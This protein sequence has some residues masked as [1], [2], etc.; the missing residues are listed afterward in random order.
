MAR[1]ALL[2]LFIFNFKDMVKR[3]KTGLV[4]LALFMILFVY[5]N[6]VFAS[7]HRYVNTIEDFNELSEKTNIDVIFYGSSHAYTA[8]NPLIINSECKT[9]SYNLGSD[10][11]KISMTD[12]VLE[13][14]IKRTR[15]KLII[16]EVYRGIL[17]VSEY[18][19]TSKGLQLRALDLVSNISLKKLSEMR[20][21]YNKDE[22]LGAM[23]PLIRNHSEWRDKSFTELSKRVGFEDEDFYSSGYVGYGRIIDMRHKRANFLDFRN[24][25]RKINSKEH[26]LNEEVK[27]SIN[28]FIEIAKEHSIPVL[29]VTSPDLREPYMNNFLFIEFD[30]FFSNINVP[31]LNLNDFYDEMDLTINDFRDPGHLNVSGGVKVTRFLSNYI[32]KNYFLENRSSERVWRNL[33]SVYK[34]SKDLLKSRINYKY[35]NSEEFELLENLVI[36][37]FDLFKVNDKIEIS[38]GFKESIGFK[39]LEGLTIGFKIFPRNI[40]ELSDRSRTKKWL[41]DYNGFSL[42]GASF[43]EFIQ[44]NSKVTD[45][46]KIEVF[47]YNTEKYT[48]VVGKKLTLNDIMS[49]KGRSSER[50]GKNL[51]SVNK[52]SRD[53]LKNRINYEYT[54]SEEFELL[55]NLVINNLDLFKGND[56]VEITLDFKESIGF[57]TLE[58]LTIGF[59]VFPRNINELSDRSRS[60]KW[61]YD[62]GEFSLKGASFKEYIQLNSRITDVEK[63][64]VF[65]YN[66]EKY[67]G[68]VGKKLTLNDVVF[69]IIEE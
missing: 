43:K 33:D 13:E 27:E 6:K 62:Y 16:L 55:E 61:L 42:K 67:T 17:N 25:N 15:P 1:V 34:S 45:V 24:K 11:L 35:T 44:L 9:I 46:D 7:S 52:S 60:K 51:D 10:G 56:K 48:G 8:F 4:F 2:N 39:T 31:Y 19:K 50:V 20:N 21:V 66:T 64:E 32:N 18:S 12:L 5:L 3:I 63:I 49:Q 22:I 36:N 53:L 65:L 26:L 29:I 59:K 47:L 68:V 58:G 57:K 41:Y 69:Q 54:N 37:N 28:E 14:S 23:F 30:G 38:L 40:N